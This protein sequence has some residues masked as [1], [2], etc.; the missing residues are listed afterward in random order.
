M[1][2]ALLSLL[3]MTAP[4]SAPDY[5]IALLHPHDTTLEGYSD[6]GEVHIGARLVGLA[7]VV[8]WLDG[9]MDLREIELDRN[10]PDA[11]PLGDFYAVVRKD[12]YGHLHLDDISQAK[13]GFCIDALRN[14]ALAQAITKL[15]QCF[16]CIRP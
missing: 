11:Q 13:N 12:E 8:E 14:E 4:A 3:V 1:R 6:N 2:A 5:A 15:R 7:H 10:V 9:S 16:P